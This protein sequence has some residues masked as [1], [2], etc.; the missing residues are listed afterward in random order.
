MWH[1]SPP[2]FISAQRLHRLALVLLAAA[3]GATVGVALAQDRRAG[4]LDVTCAANCT[5]HGYEPDFCGKVCWV[6]DPGVAARSVPVDWVCMSEC[7]DR[8]GNPID[9]KTRCRRP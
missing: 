3:L 6:P 2:R 9:C 4:Q 7:L 1:A 8:L 5:T